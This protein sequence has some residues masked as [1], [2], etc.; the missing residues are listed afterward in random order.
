MQSR[1]SGLKKAK[2]Q[3]E[4]YFW[5]VLTDEDPQQRYTKHYFLIYEEKPLD[6]ED[7]PQRKP[8]GSNKSGEKSAGKGEKKPK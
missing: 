6:L 3:K 8:A 4:I 1:F 2:G 7:S 5:E